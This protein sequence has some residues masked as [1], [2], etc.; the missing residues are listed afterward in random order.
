MTRQSSPQALMMI[1]PANFGFNRETAESN[2]FQQDK[3]ESTEEIQK[4]ALAEFDS[5]VAL[6][7]KNEIE[8]FIVEDT[9]SPVK[10]D[11]IFPNN[12]IS[13]HP[14]G[15]LVSYPMMAANRRLE[16]RADIIE[17]LRDRYKVEKMIG[18][19]PWEQQGKFL[20]GTGSLI[21]D[22]ANAVAYACRS[23][24]TAETLVKQ[25]CKEIG[26]SSVIFDSSDEQ[27]KPIYHTNV[28][29]WLGERMAGVCLD[30]IKTD[31]D[32]EAVLSKLAESS[33]KVIA[34]SYHQIKAFAG[35]MFEVRNRK[36]EVF[37]LMSQT[38][39]ESLLPGQTNE[40]SKHAEP[41]IVSIDTIEHYGGGGIR[42]MVAG[43]Y[44]P[45]K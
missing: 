33:H 41:L 27:G 30:S 24:R 32:Q 3:K 21:F 40:I 25:V 31:E 13:T 38:A 11:A 20:E 12:W 8:V 36:G 9:A 35:N 19:E 42:C 44:L 2:A 6:L 7:R 14:E 34:L 18:L 5:T 29:M 16:R 22:H 1:R 39:F 45:S 23:P 4:K 26:Y 10:P 28:M 15:I 17:L 37:L 43:M